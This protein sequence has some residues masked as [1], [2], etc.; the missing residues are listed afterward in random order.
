MARRI[1]GGIMKNKNRMTNN[2]MKTLLR[3]IEGL[4]LMCYDTVQTKE[5]LKRVNEEMYVMAHAP[6]CSKQCQ[7]KALTL[8]KEI[9]KELKIARV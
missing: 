5:N 3:A 8:A 7:D 1:V 9:I 6:M 2:D 4:C